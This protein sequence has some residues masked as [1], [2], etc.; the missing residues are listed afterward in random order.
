[1]QY[2]NTCRLVALFLHTPMEPYDGFTSSQAAYGA[3]N[4]GANWNNQA[5]KKAKSYLEL[6]SF[7]RDELIN[8]LEYEGFTRAQAE[9]GA[10]QN[11][12]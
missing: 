6:M 12:Y 3:D 9:Y 1:M 5:A 8:Q 4:C 11:G 2:V 7:S 10:A